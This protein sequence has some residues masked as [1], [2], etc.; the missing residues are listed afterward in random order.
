M[1]RA[2]AFARVAN[3]V[4]AVERAAVGVM[5]RRAERVFGVLLALIVLLYLLAVPTSHWPGL[6]PRGDNVPLPYVAGWPGSAA[7]PQTLLLDEIH[8]N[9]STVWH[10]HSPSSSLPEPIFAEPAL[11]QEQQARYH[12][13]RQPA[14]AVDPSSPPA[15]YMF[16]AV[17]KDIGA[18]LPDLVNAMA[19]TT[20]FLGPERVSFS[21]IEGPSADPTPHI[22]RD[23]L[24]PMLL[25]SVSPSPRSPSRATRPRS[26]GPK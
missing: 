22:L 12:H 25:P 24:L 16:A 17:L 15:K 26:R 11:T 21:I 4:S 23:V 6:L 10:T 19:V 3:A 7:G 8:A 20:A 2:L 9:F 18:Q 1:L 5:E 13:L 14:A